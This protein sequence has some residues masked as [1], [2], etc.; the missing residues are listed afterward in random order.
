MICIERLSAPGHFFSAPSLHCRHQQMRCFAAEAIPSNVSSLSSVLLHSAYIEYVEMCVQECVTKHMLSVEAS[1]SQ[2]L[3]GDIATVEN[4]QREQQHAT[5]T[6]A[7]VVIWDST[8]KG[9]LSMQAQALVIAHG[10]DLSVEQILAHAPDNGAYRKSTI[11]GNKNNALPAG[12]T[13]IL[14][15]DGLLDCTQVFNAVHAHGGS[16]VCPRVLFASMFGVHGCLVA[17][18]PHGHQLCAGTEGGEGKQAPAA[19]DN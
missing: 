3:E 12:V 14:L 1:T 19:Q 10:T 13:S 18:E 15:K 4:E 9:G 8:Q 7:G 2:A 11:K 5:E 6:E 16:K 17:T